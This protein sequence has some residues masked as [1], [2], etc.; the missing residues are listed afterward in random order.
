MDDPHIGKGVAQIS[1]SSSLF[2]THTYMNVCANMYVYICMWIYLCVYVCIYIYVCMY[3][4]IYIHVY[5]CVHACA[6][7]YII[8]CI[9]MHISDP[10]RGLSIASHSL[11]K[12]WFCMGS[13]GEVCLRFCIL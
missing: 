12:V 2:S 13:I 7:I 5:M 1:L 3:M 4:Y 6:H 10:F 11:S 8:V 9:Y